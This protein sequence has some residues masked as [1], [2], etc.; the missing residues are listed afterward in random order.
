MYIPVN[1]EEM[2]ARLVCNKFR[3]KLSEELVVSKTHPSLYPSS[4]SFLLPLQK[5]RNHLPVVDDDDKRIAPML[6]T[7]KHCYLGEALRSSTVRTVPQEHWTHTGPSYGLLE[8]RVCQE[9]GTREGV[10]YYR[11]ML[12]I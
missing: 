9:N 4:T 7:I 1:N 11:H 6:K 12:Y 5:T 3:Q 10:H 2:I 8:S